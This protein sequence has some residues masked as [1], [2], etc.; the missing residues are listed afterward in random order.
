M[1]IKMKTIDHFNRE[2]E[3]LFKIFLRRIGF[4]NFDDY[5]KLFWNDYEKREETVEW[6]K[7]TYPDFI[8]NKL[9]QWKD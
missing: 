4:K 8:T 1:K 2:K 9:Q 5:M 7:E 3:P 6:F